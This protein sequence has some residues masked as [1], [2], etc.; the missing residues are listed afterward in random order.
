MTEND[1]VIKPV[2]AYSNP[3]QPQ[4]L[5]FDFDEFDSAIG[6]GPLAEMDDCSL[7]IEG[8]GGCVAVTFKTER[9]ETV[10]SCNPFQAEDIAKRLMAAADEAIRSCGLLAPVEG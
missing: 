7:V 9:G 3:N 1:V 5:A 10:L 6:F 2:I 4:E 8:F